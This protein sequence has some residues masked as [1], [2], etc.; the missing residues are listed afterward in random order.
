MWRRQ[1]RNGETEG[2]LNRQPTSD[3]KKLKQHRKGQEDLTQPLVKCAL[4]RSTHP[5]R[6]PSLQP[7]A[8]ES[9]DTES[10]TNFNKSSVE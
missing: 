7:P 1:N 5:N 4:E 10:T 9:Y 3:R 8:T 6:D 2:E